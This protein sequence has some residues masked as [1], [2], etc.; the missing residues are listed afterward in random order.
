MRDFSFCPCSQA[1]ERVIVPTGDWFRMLTEDACVSYLNSLRNQ[2]S[3]SLKGHWFP[4]RNQVSLIHRQKSGSE[5]TNHKQCLKAENKKPHS[6]S[7]TLNIVFAFIL[8][9][10]I[11]PAKEEREP[12]EA[13]PREPEPGYTGRAWREGRGGWRGPGRRS[14]EWGPSLRWET[15][16]K[17]ALCLVCCCLQWWLNHHVTWRKGSSKSHLESGHCC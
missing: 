13:V 7:V 8:L 2:E 6:V 10:Y 9:W 17:D 16:L 4:W 11:K 5:R 14:R 15:Q 1:K 3:F 12:W